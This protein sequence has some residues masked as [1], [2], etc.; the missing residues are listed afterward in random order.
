MV[1]EEVAI[2]DARG[3]QFAGVLPEDAP[4]PRLEASRRLLGLTFP[5]M[6]LVPRS[7]IE[8]TNSPASMDAAG[9]AGRSQLAVSFSY[10]LAKP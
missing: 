8:D 4:D 6:G 9:G 5:L 1:A 2:R 7:T 10:T 3:M